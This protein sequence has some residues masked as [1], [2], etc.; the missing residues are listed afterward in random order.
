MCVVLKVRRGKDHSVGQQ[1][2]GQARHAG[3]D[4]V[5]VRKTSHFNYT[6]HD[7]GKGDLKNIA[8]LKNEAK[9]CL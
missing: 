2:G 6:P 5:V 4:D 7:K 8:F 1:G 9:K 3:H